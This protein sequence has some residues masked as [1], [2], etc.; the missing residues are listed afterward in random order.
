MQTVPSA[1]LSSPSTYERIQR[2]SDDISSSPTCDERAAASRS[3]SP[4][5]QPSLRR[6]T[7]VFMASSLIDRA[8]LRSGAPRHKH[9]LE[10]LAGAAPR[11]AID[12]T[13]MAAVEPQ[14]RTL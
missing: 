9:V 11:A 1:P 2:M 14:P 10:V 8:I 13:A 4:S 5:R 7:Y 3:A 12:V 6:I